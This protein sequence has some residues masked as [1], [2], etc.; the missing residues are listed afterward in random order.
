[1]SLV[2]DPIFRIKV[3]EDKQD[4]HHV[5]L[6]ESILTIQLSPQHLFAEELRASQSY[7]S[8]L[9]G[10]LSRLRSSLP[11]HDTFT[12]LSHDGPEANVT[13]ECCFFDSFAH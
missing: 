2:L 4:S 9:A 1:M 6:D 7:Y 3:S 11:L 8:N 12:D 10:R 5:A 13:V